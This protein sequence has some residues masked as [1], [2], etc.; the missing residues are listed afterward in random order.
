MQHL[1]P[2]NVAI[3][4]FC[5]V[6]NVLP[7]I[8]KLFSLIFSLEESESWSR[9]NWDTLPPQKTFYFRNDLL[10]FTETKKHTLDVLIT[11]PRK[12]KWDLGS[13]FALAKDYENKLHNFLLL[14]SFI[15]NGFRQFTILSLKNK[16]F[17]SFWILLFDLGLNI[18][19]VMFELLSGIYFIAGE[20]KLWETLPESLHSTWLKPRIN[21]NYRIT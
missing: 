4:S 16:I 6:L 21:C 17:K 8:R 14:L 2:H 10:N 7:F 19:A 5:D 3:F 9:R 12:H 11:F 18:F 15:K 20:A 13:T 1:N